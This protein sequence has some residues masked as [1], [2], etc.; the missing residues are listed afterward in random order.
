MR[1]MT[2]RYLISI[3]FALLVF[4]RSGALDASELVVEHIANA[5]VKISSG[6]KSVLVDALFGPHDYFNSLTDEEFV[7]LSRQGA[8]VALATHK[9]SDH[10]GANRITAFLLRNSAT[11]FIGTPESLKMLDHASI[12]GQLHS[13]PLT[14][15]D[16]KVLFL[17]GIKVTVLNFPHMR[18]LEAETKNFGFL[19]EIDGWRVLHVGDA[20]INGEVIDG[21]QLADRNIDV[22]LIHDLFP[23]RK[24]NYGKLIKKMNVQKVAFI[25]MTD[26]KAEPMVRWLKQNLPDATL[27]VTGHERLSMKRG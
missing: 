19:V 17:N 23:V 15:F 10:F 4:W 11:Q 8:E 24:R 18:P 14:G 3:T 12:Q 5:G 6:G 21:L 27:L 22:V 1:T 7:A 2:S 25:H 13:A 26:N 9:H 20:D 16:T